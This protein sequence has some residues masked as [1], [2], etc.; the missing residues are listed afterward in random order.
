MNLF[1]LHQRPGVSLGARRGERSDERLPVMLDVPFRVVLGEAKV[2]RFTAVA[3]GNPA[4]PSTEAVY[5]P[6]ER[7][8]DG[9]AQNF[10]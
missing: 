9:R 2:E 8:E 4:L 1:D 6:G 5:Q 3:V 10:Q 7:C